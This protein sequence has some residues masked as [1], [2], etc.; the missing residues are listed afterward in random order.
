MRCFH[1]TIKC[2]F[3]L[4]SDFLGEYEQYL[5]QWEVE[6]AKGYEEIYYP[7]DV[8]VYLQHTENMVESTDY[9]NGTYKIVS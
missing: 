3:V 8:E 2:N 1:L 5:P 9:G 6:E 7:G 4:F